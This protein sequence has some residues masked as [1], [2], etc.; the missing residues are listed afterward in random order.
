MNPR[1]RVLLEMQAS[2]VAFVAVF[3]FYMCLER[4]VDRKL[5]V[6]G[7]NIYD[8]IVSKTHSGTVPVSHPIMN[9]VKEMSWEEKIL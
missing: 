5:R 4:S 2:S 1:N 3:N 7:S 6:I 9:G 8:K